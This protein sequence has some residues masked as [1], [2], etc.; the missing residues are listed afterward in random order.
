MKV[1][2]A[3]SWMIFVL[4]ASAFAILVALV[5]QAQSF[6]RHE[7]WYEPIRE[8]G[9]FGEYPGYYNTH[10]GQYAGGHMPYGYPMPMQVGNGQYMHQPGQSIVIQPGINGQPATVSTVPLGAA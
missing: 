5:S 10:A 4:I 3:F 7:I 9:W 6:G 2:Q 1:I 8:L